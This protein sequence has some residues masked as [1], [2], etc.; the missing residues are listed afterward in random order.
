[1]R[2]LSIASFL[3]V[4]FLTFLAVVYAIVAGIEIWKTTESATYNREIHPEL[5]TDALE[6]ARTVE[7][8]FSAEHRK[9]KGLW[10]FFALPPNAVPNGRLNLTMRREGTDTPIW[11]Q[12]FECN[13]A[14]FVGNAQLLRVAGVDD[15]EKGAR[16]VLTYAMPE[17]KS[18]TGWPLAYGASEEATS[19]VRWDSRVC[20]SSAPSMQ[21]LEREPRFP[22]RN[23]LFGGALMLLCALAAKEHT[24]FRLPVL[25]VAVPSCILAATYFWQVH[26]WQF[27]GNF[28]PDGYPGLGYQASEWLTGRITARQCLASFQH[29][30][31][32]QIFTVPFVMG[33]FR[34]L[35]LSL[36]HGYIAANAVFLTVAAGS[37]FGL[38]NLYGIKRD[39]AVIAMILFFF[40]NVCVIGAVGEMQSDLGG[41]AATL[42]F[43][44][45]FARAL[46]ET[47]P[48]RRY[49]WFIACGVAGFLACTVRL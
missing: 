2:R 18:G 31:T 38:L 45:T 25:I 49:G 24:L 15:L 30:R 9:L 5:H 13:Q 42:F 20:M 37:L 23:L 12:S 6:G 40:G 36:K 11:S 7:Y 26:L 27:W 47:D 29:D 32:G 22:R 10:V 35:G 48:C 3:D 39:R 1:M 16:Y 14:Q 44:Y 43:I 19:S 21:W 28:W 34:A 4:R 17:M 46:E 41:V 33:T 8:A